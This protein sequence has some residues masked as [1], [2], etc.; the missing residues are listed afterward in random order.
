M[1]SVVSDSVSNSLRVVKTFRQV[2]DVKVSYGECLTLNTLN[3][4]GRSFG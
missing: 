2:N 1:S 4:W 3:D